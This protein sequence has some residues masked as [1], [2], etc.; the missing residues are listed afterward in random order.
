MAQSAPDTPKRRRSSTHVPLTTPL[1][2]REPQLLPMQS[3]PLVESGGLT[4]IRETRAEIA[5]PNAT[6][7]VTSENSLEPPH[8]RGPGCNRSNDSQEYS[9]FSWVHCFVPLFDS[10]V[11]EPS[12]PSCPFRY[13]E[14]GKNGHYVAGRQLSK[15][16]RYL[17][18][19]NLEQARKAYFQHLLTTCKQC[20]VPENHPPHVQRQSLYSLMARGNGI[21]LNVEEVFLDLCFPCQDDRDL[22][23]LNAEGCLDLQDHRVGI[24]K[25]GWYLQQ[26]MKGKKWKSSDNNIT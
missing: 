10:L 3:T 5:S 26:V 9:Q 15:T 7:S 20:T 17:D 11:A 1:R 12:D 22:T 4:P 14:F 18:A 19:N 6:V 16:F 8:K 21:V 13:C 23:R 24:T 25:F 2:S